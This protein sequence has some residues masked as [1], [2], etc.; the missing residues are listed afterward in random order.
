MIRL[1]HYNSGKNFQGHICITVR[2]EAGSRCSIARDSLKCWHCAWGRCLTSCVSSHWVSS[3]SHL[4]T[5]LIFAISIICSC[6][7]CNQ[8]WTLTYHFNPRHYF[9]PSWLNCDWKLKIFFETPANN[10][11]TKSKSKSFWRRYNKVILIGLKTQARAFF[12]SLQPFDIS[13]APTHCSGGLAPQD[14]LEVTGYKTTAIL[15]TA[16]YV[17]NVFLWCSQFYKSALQ[18][19]NWVKAS[20]KL[21]NSWCKHLLVW[22]TRVPSVVVLSVYISRILCWS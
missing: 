20:F 2:K 7:M 9:F 18:S 11:S 16:L 17:R 19:Q 1:H 22:M 3:H 15:T 14:Y 5:E 8:K 6:T 13:P 12:Q 10:T 21:S 4:Q